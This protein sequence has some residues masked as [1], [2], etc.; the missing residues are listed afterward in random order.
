MKVETINKAGE[1]TSYYFDPQHKAEVIGFYQKIFWLGDITG[2]KATM[3]N[4]EIVA[5]G[6]SK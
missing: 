6:A 1:S 5:V 3:D 2:Y 4:G